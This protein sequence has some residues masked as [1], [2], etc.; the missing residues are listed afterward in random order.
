[1]LL[2]AGI[3]DRSSAYVA[4]LV[5][6]M[7][8][9]ICGIIPTLQVPSLFGYHAGVKL[10]GIVLAMISVASMTAVPLTN[11][12]RDTLGSYRPVFVGTAV[13]V[14]FVIGL[15]LVLFNQTNKDRKEFENMQKE[16]MQGR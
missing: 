11:T 12:L 14:V 2:L 13:V 1:M 6:A 4:A 8:L 9:P 7:G 16:Q 10:M 5:Y 15:Y 3:K